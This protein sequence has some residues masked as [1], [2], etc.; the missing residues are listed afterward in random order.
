MKNYLLCFSEVIVQLVPTCFFSP[1]VRNSS[2]KYTTESD[3]AL[4]HEMSEKKKVKL[5]SNIHPN[6]LSEIIRL[7]KNGGGG[8]NLNQIPYFQFYMGIAA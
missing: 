7:L 3:I 5:N 4:V 2:L 6:I 8:G 1:I